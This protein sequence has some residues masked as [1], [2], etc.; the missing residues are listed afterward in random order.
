MAG[1]Q[2]KQEPE[3]GALDRKGGSRWLHAVWIFAL[4]VSTSWATFEE[5]DSPDGFQIMPWLLN[6]SLALI[7]TV[8][9]VAATLIIGKLLQLEQGFAKLASRI[10]RAEKPITHLL[11]RA[12]EIDTSL[13]STSESLHASRHQA[14]NPSSV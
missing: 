3:L 8:I 11:N 6:M 14:L 2:E 12:S 4:V 13:R 7:I 5:L 1:P 10:E 9:S